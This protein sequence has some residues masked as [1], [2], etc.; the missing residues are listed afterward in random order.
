[1][2]AF[3]GVYEAFVGGGAA[4]VAIVCKFA[5]ACGGALHGGEC[6]AGVVA[7]VGRLVFGG[8]ALGE[9]RFFFC[10][11]MSEDGGEV[12]FGS[13]EL[14]VGLVGCCQGWDGGDDRGRL[15]D[16]PGSGWLG[17]GYGLRRLVGRFGD[18]G[19][20]V[21]EAEDADGEDGSTTLEHDLCTFF[22][23]GGLGWAAWDGR[24]TRGGDFKR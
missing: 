15:V 22:G 6:A 2:D 8:C 23:M 12:L 4:G 7:D 16:G 3:A 5:E 20:A 10:V 11:S 24:S 19:T 17:G 13:A 14:V 18:G 21:E 9:G 1:M